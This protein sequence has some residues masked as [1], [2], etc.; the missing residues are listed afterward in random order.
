MP[1][2]S[3]APLPR[4]VLDVHAAAGESP[5]WDTPRQLLHWVDIFGCAL[6]CYDP[7][8]GRDTLLPMPDLVTFVAPHVDGG[9]VVALRRA[10]VHVAED[11]TQTPVATPPL[12]PGVRLNDGATDPMGRLWIGSMALPENPD[13]DGVLWRIDLDGR[14]DPVIH[15]LRTANGLAFAPD[16]RTL[17]L[18]DSHP[19]VRTIYAFDY[20]PLSGTVS[21]RRTFVR[22]HDLVGR[23]D[24]GCVDREGG[25]WMAAVDGWS[26]LRFTG[27]GRLDASIRFP[28]EK[29]SK[30]CFGG[31]GLDVLYV[32]SLRRNLSAPLAAQPL[33][34]GL[35]AVLPG[36]K[37]LPL[38]YCAIPLAPRH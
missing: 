29:P 24:G 23:P 6:H 21:G 12:G 11:G 13:A 34:G 7:A 27:E 30:A 26:L 9:R 19:D 5:F 17:Y 32:T 1:E 15:G 38:A 18:S 31:P 10:I 8:A 14:C 36:R 22:T 16:G 37:G 3:A 4:C 35:F 20:E 2:T 25:Y 28:V 33:A